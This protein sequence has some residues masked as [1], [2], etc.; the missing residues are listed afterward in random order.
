MASGQTPITPIAASRT[1]TVIAWRRPATIS[2]I[3][4]APAIRSHQ[5]VPTMNERSGSRPQVTTK[6]PKFE[7]TG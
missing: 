4:T 5:G 6:S 1:P 3:S 2:A 7:V